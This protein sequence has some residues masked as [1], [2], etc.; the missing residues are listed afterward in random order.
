MGDYENCN[1]DLAVCF[2]CGLIY[3]AEIESVF[4]PKKINRKIESCPGCKSKDR[5]LICDASLGRE[6]RGFQTT[7]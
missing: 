1:V 7:E 5:R 3:A 2:S 4:N 6:W